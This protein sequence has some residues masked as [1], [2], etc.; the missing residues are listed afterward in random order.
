MTAPFFAEFDG[1][2]L[3]VVLDSEVAL[4]LLL[5]V[6]VGDFDSVDPGLNVVALG[7][8]AEVVPLALFECALLFAEP[9]AEANA[10]NAAGNG[11]V[12]FDLVAFGFSLRALAAEGEARVE[13]RFI[14]EED[15]EF[16]FEVGHFDFGGDPDV[17]L[18]EEVEFAVF[19]FEAFDLFAGSPAAGGCSVEEI[20]PFGLGEGDRNK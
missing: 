3:A 5:V 20:D 11:A 10:V 16:G 17:N 2:A 8:D 19:R 15:F 1:T 18:G 6:E 13:A 4:E 7:H 9:A 12:D 14:G